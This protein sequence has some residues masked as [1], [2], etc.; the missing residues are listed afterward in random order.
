MA[1]VSFSQRRLWLLHQFEPGDPSYNVPA[2][3]QIDGSLKVEALQK[4]LREIARRHESLR[5]RFKTLQGEPQQLIEEEI[6]LE[7]VTRDLTAV[8][9]EERK[10][11]ADDLAREEGR[12]P[13][14]LGRGPLIRAIL[15]RLDEEEHMLLLTMHHIISDGWSAGV[16][17]KEL[18]T[19]YVAFSA[20]RPSPL[21]ELA[22]QYADFSEWQLE[23]L[24][25]EMLE[26]QLEYWKAQLA[27]VAPLDLPATYRRPTVMSHA[28]AKIFFQLGNSVSD[29]LRELGLRE[30]ATLYMVLLAAFQTLLYRYS[31]QPDIAVGTPVAGRKRPETEELI[32]LFVN[33]LVMRTQFSEGW[34]FIEL[35]KQVKETTLQAFSHQDV[36]FEKLVE[37]LMPQ[38]DL[39]RTPLFQVMFVLQNAPSAELKVGGTR[40]RLLNFDTAVSKFDLTLTLAEAGGDVGGNFEYNTDLFDEAAVQRTIEHFRILLRGI[41]EDPSQQIAMLPLL[42]GGERQE[43]LLEWNKTEAHYP[44]QKTLIEFIE[45]Q[46]LRTPEA[47]A[48][49]S[50]EEKLNYRE[51]NRRANQLGH[52][53]IKLGAGP[54]VR[55]GICMER[56]LEMVVGL[57]G[58][59]K[60]GGAYVPLDPAYPVDRLAYMV[61]DARAGIILTQEKLAEGLTTYPGIL[62][63]VD[64]EWQRI[65]TESQGN[66]PA[67]VVPENMMYMIYTSGSTGR[68]KGAM[69]IY[70]GVVNRLLWIQESFHLGEQDRVLQKTPFSFD[71]SVGEFF[72][73]LMVGAE[74]VMARPGGHQ[75]VEY[76]GELIQQRGITSV[77]FVPSMLNVFLESP[78]VQKCGSLRLVMCSGEALS[79]DVAKK[80]LE[81]VGAELRN[82]YGPTEA[83]V[84]VT[85]WK[86]TEEEL[87]KGASIGKPIKNIQAYVLDAVMEPV[88]VGIA[89][90]LYLGGV[91]L[92]RGYWNRPD[93]TAERFIPDPFSPRNGDRLYRT[94]DWVRWKADGNLEYIGRR[95]D[96]IKIRG[97]RIELGEIERALCNCEG[98]KQAL[99][100]AR[101]DR[102]GDK[103]LVAYLVQSQETDRSRLRD[104][105]KRVLPEYMVP[106]AF[107]SLDA[108]PLTPNGKINR[109]ALPAPTRHDETNLAEFVA[110]RTPLEE[111]LAKI[112]ADV[113]GIEQVGINDNFFEIG[114]HSLLATQAGA[115]IAD[116][117]R[118]E[119]PLRRLFEAPTIAQL[120][121]VVEQLQAGGE[122]NDNSKPKIT[123]VARK[124]V[125]MPSDSE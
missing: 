104:E 47:T 55:V 12:R 75:D 37:V 33:T 112:W 25:P 98:V 64:A 8:P 14:N 86:C 74:L 18:T 49:S 80:C 2:A 103:R 43:L 24:S 92:A 96:Q 70:R 71:V 39:S 62:V 30:G 108:L 99:V 48:V 106:S 63:K 118:V 52:Y 61:E 73:P 38:R 41:A 69:N 6:R 29:Q 78:A 77:H 110:P 60:A 57:L 15:L 51:L 114:G 23:W 21:P 1:P 28:G 4:S 58:I 53:L 82:L 116:A 117:C 94:G 68:P 76:L 59:L 19:L 35:L 34:S 56:S 40:L 125:R 42:S 27:G 11:H 10:N 79:A 50:G 88:P 101:E 20:G 123:R 7:L 66:P 84:E 113:L 91:G 31:G 13:F 97:F 45:E 121:I 46:V 107:V 100:V 105:L 111:Q 93:L 36:P 5:T 72:W 32:G 87:A 9:L 3:V 109:Q 54:E 16:L 17:V 26:P 102:S 124:A 120:A 89:G 85:F 122:Q 67:R 81:R 83:S 119:L 22:I 44:L 90:E 115:R 95:D 65:G